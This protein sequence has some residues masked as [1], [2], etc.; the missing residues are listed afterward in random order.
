MTATHVKHATERVTY[1][2]PTGVFEEVVRGEVQDHGGNVLF[3]GT[4]DQCV[5]KTFR[6]PTILVPTE[7]RGRLFIASADHMWSAR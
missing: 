2:G 6:V 5:A 1:E 3:A 7:T 4:P